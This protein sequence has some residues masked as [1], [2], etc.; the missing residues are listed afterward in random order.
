VK[1]LLL[2]LYAVSFLGCTCLFAYLIWNV[3]FAHVVE[4]HRQSRQAF[5]SVAPESGQKPDKLTFQEAIIESDERVKHYLGYRV[6]EE[7][8]LKGH[9]HHIDF[10]FKQD[11]QL[12]CINCHGD[13]PHD[14]TKQIR[15]FN[16]MHA[17]F[18]A[19]QTCHVRF[20]DADR[21]AG[22]Q[23][24]DR[25]T[26]A[27]VSSPLNQKGPPGAYDAKIIPLERADNRVQRID[28]RERIDFAREYRQNE[29]GLSDLQKAKAKKL[30]H[31]IV[32][33]KP[34]LCEECHTSE[35]SILP[36]Q[37]L[38]YPYQRINA[39]TSTEVVGMIKNYSKFYIPHL[40]QPGFGSKS[41]KPVGE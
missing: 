1:K 41:S 22:F 3:T 34:H 9:F 4:E 37:A 31:N 19:C 30:I 16:N 14:K 39:I 28:T 2:K 15:A 23:W 12:Y 26:G 36:F 20:D 38:G 24:Y 35:N 10:D 7:T 5:A 6:L 27:T 25:S 32:S 11:Q 18:L 40:L 13:M 21:A 29:K 17:S 33:Q 8:W